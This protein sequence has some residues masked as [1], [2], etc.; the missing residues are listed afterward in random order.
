MSTSVARSIAALDES[1][2]GVVVCL[3]D[4]PRVSA[5]TIDRLIAA[6]DPLEGRAICVATHNGKRGNPMIF[7]RRFFDEVRELSGDLGA[8]HLTGAYPD[9]TCDVE[10]TEDGVLLDI[11]TPSALARIRS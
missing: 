2:D 4:M 7:A 3:G 6:F 1:V 8:R 5:A 10:M 9:L 11:D